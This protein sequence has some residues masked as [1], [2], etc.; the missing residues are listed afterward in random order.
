TN[1]AQPTDVAPAPEPAS[2]SDSFM[3]AGGNTMTVAAPAEE[4]PAEDTPAEETPAEDTP[5]EDTPAEDTPAEDTPAED[6][7]ERLAATLDQ[8]PLVEV[9]GESA[10]SVVEPA[11]V[12]PEPVWT[13]V[14][15]EPAPASFEPIAIA[16]VPASYEPGFTRVQAPAPAVEPEPPVE[17]WWPTAQPDPMA[18]ATSVELVPPVT[19]P[20]ELAAPLE[21]T[22]SAPV[23]NGGDDQGTL[24]SELGAYELVVGPFAKFSS[25]NDFLRAV[26]KLN[27]V[28]DVRTR[29]FQRGML[30]VRVE[31]E[32]Q[33]PLTRRLREV[34]AIP[35]TIKSASGN[36][37]EVVVA[38]Q[39]S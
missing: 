33:V 20:P 36:Q 32:N 30:Q 16:P 10:P 14:A 12:T 15:V 28:L 35:M 4:T 8:A 18:T 23:E 38:A 31:Y 37:I 9:V 26:R 2:A 3:A 24:G 39:A 13:P 19:A 17:P 5:A 27:G 11:R 7:I 6:T 1:A 34:E 25:V 29:R 21:A 22:Q